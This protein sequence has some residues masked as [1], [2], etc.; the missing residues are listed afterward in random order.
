MLAGMGSDN[1][2][3]SLPGIT[4]ALRLLP[5]LA[6]AFAVVIGVAF[7]AAWAISP[8]LLLNPYSE[9][10]SVKPN[11]ALCL[12]LAGAALLCAQ[13]GRPE[14]W[15][16]A[17][18]LVLGGLVAAIGGF[19]LAEYFANRDLGLDHLLIPGPPVTPSPI[20]MP[21]MAAAS[22]LFVGIA[23]VMTCGGA[24]T[25][26]IGRVSNMAAATIAAVGVVAY[27]FGAG[28]ELRWPP[29]EPAMA[30]P[31]A[32]AI[33]FLGVGLAAAHREGAIF[34]LL[35]RDDMAGMLVR[36]LAVAGA[37]VPFAAGWIRLMG[38][39]AGLYLAGFGLAIMVSISTVILLVVVGIA[40]RAL[41]EAERKRLEILAD[42]KQSEARFR[43][44]LEA[45]PDAILVVDTAG[46]IRLVNAQ[47]ESLFGHRREDL[48][49]QTV[50]ALIPP[51]FREDHPAR[52]DKFFEAPVLVTASTPGPE[53]WA[54]RSDGTEFP[55]EITL[56]PFEEN[57]ERLVT[58]IVRDVTGLRDAQ[59]ELARRAEALARSN[60]ELEQ[61]AY[62]ASHDLQ[63][64]LRS[65]V[66]FMQLAERRM[67]D[68][69]DPDARRFVGRAIDASARMQALI[70][71]LLAY[72]RVGRMGQ[73]LRPVRLDDVLD[74]TLAN[75]RAAIEQSGAE[76]SRPVEM[77]AVRGDATQLIQL[78]QNLIANAIKFKGEKPPR[79]RIAAEK[80]AGEWIVSVADEGI[81]IDPRYYDRIFVIFQRL[82]S[83]KHY[84]GTGIGLSLC[85]KIVERHEGRIWVE[86]TPGKGATF[87]IAL[88]QVSRRE[89]GQEGLAL[90]TR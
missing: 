23:L 56:S 55:V 31:A 9:W 78:F 17:I 75:L 27:L 26:R 36:R 45:A 57:G 65:V 16:R 43:T 5:F 25:R 7:F 41:A 73:P 62:V 33:L 85:K 24:L 19:T 67:G 54:V 59:A 38:E 3:S 86:S 21:P 47:V 83:R 49:G 32:A 39:R 81:G 37:L 63:E 80:Q 76:I 15:C 66:S 13:N 14:G 77:P 48:L 87:F 79:I 68:A 4:E 88:P 34:S 42:L 52:R 35:D 72:S 64:P 8:E 82:H 90:A 29:G 74:G 71:D 10:L 11:M 84:E 46:R 2:A 30:M 53:R 1:S 28:A 69:M 51:R 12:V 58:A 89:K 50:E 40:A 18:V 22:V 20:R 61:F 44:L 6:G 60:A 70:Q